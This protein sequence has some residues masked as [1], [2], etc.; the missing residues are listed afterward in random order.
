MLRHLHH[1]LSPLFPPISSPVPPPV[2][3]SVPPPVPPLP[4]DCLSHAI[5]LLSCV[6]GL[7][8]FILSILTQPFLFLL[9]ALMSIFSLLVPPLLSSSPPPPP[10]TPPLHSL[11]GLLSSSTLL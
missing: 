1:R 2:P 8:S 6:N 7:H 5:S 9:M 4:S 11:S 3:P 10:T